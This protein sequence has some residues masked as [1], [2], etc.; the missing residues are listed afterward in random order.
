VVAV[1][2]VL[3]VKPK[4][5]EEEE[6]GIMVRAGISQSV[7]RQSV[8]DSARR[9]VGRYERQREW[10]AQGKARQAREWISF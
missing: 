8:L 5:E 6:E 10:G 7:S 2:F 9:G 1:F 4:E 3:L